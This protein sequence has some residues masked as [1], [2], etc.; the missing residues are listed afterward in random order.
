MVKLYNMYC[1]HCKKETIGVISQLSRT[2]GAKLRC[3]ECQNESKSYK[4]IQSLKL[5]SFEKEQEAFDKENQL[6]KEVNKQ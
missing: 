3:V 6:N 1:K 4:N 2:K 5:Y